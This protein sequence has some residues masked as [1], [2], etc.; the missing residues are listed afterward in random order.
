MFINLLEGTKYTKDFFEKREKAKT[1][2]H[3]FAAINRFF[4]YIVFC[5]TLFATINNKKLHLPT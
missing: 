1:G 4:L 2:K 5:R 3:V